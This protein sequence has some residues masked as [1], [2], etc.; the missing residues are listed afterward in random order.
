MAT[1]AGE[2]QPSKP[3]AL[4]FSPL[5]SYLIGGF[6]AADHR[7]SSGVPVAMLDATGHATQFARNYA[8]LRALG[9]R[10]VRE[11]IGWSRAER[12]GR[13]DF[14]CALRRADAARRA[15][16]TVLWTLWHY[17]IPDDLGLFHSSLADR[18]AAFAHAAA[19]AL[20]DDA[21]ERPIF[22]PINEISFLAWAACESTYIY[23]HRGSPGREASARGF[24]LK[25]RLVRAAIEACDA[26]REVTPSAIM[27]HID[28]LI[29]IVAPDDAPFLAAEAARA[30]EYQFQAWDMLTG[31][32]SPELG[33]APRYVDW[34]GVNYYH[35]NQ[36]EIGTDRRLHWHLRDPRRIPFSSLLNEV[37]ARYGRPV[38]VAETSHVGT[39]R[40]RWLMEV[41]REVRE[42]IR[43][44]TRVVGLCLYP[45]VDRPD[46]EEPTLW[47][48]SGL[49]D[50]FQACDGASFD[51][52]QLTYLRA[53]R[54][55][56]RTFGDDVR[57]RHGG[58]YA[59]VVLAEAPWRR[60][61]S[62]SRVQIETVANQWPVVVVEP[63]V[64]GTDSH[65]MRICEGIIV[66]TPQ[67][68]DTDDDGHDEDVSATLDALFAVLDEIGI[69]HYGVWLHTPMA[70]PVLAHLSPDVI[71][72]TAMRGAAA[73][74]PRFRQ[75]DNALRRIAD[76]VG[77][78]SVASIERARNA[79]RSAS[80]HRRV[81]CVIVGAGLAGLSAAYHYGEG[82]LLLER[83][84]TIGGSRR[85]VADGGFLFDIASC[86][87]DGRDEWTRL[88]D[89]LLGDNVAWRASTGYPL[90]GGMQAL[91]DGFLPLLAGELRRGTQVI[92][93]DPGKRAMLL[94]DGS[95]LRYERAIV[96]LPL[97]VLVALCEDVPVDVRN[98]AHRLRTRSLRCL[99][100]GVRGKAP[101]SD[102]G[103]LRV[104]ETMFDR[105]VLSGTL[106][107]TGNRRDGF[108]LA[109]EIAYA[110][111]RPLELHG[112]RLVTRCIDDCVR[113]GLIASREKVLV[114]NE[115]DLPVACVI[116]D[117]PGARNV[118]LIEGW[119]GANGIVFTGSRG[120]WE[121]GRC[122]AQ[123]AWG[124]DA[125]LA[126]AH[127][128]ERTSVASALS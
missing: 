125:A 26:I 78:V 120:E 88:Y 51:R 70:L 79:P 126:V 12:D 64:S 63:V 13:F 22:C 67:I 100:I 103:L 59:M 32:L 95:K 122:A 94:D 53:V 106:S 8:R 77:D 80:A 89:A 98:A 115:N 93:M 29:H 121:P 118:Q 37:H 74:D 14:G 75:R 40:A 66:V 44:G 62:E 9:I 28:P 35:G 38:L 83:D 16:I 34:I 21:L 1:R 42:A 128:S 23:P 69:A 127:A 56:Q 91:V 72:Y 92:R 2:L 110:R 96:N 3:E 43:D 81:E 20:H 99:N 71:A 84:T 33:G 109:C 45:I 24:A 27:L 58:C 5:A 41:S 107:P 30:R 65:A 19:S 123:L 46:W 10:V 6:E 57:A 90:Y 124:R 112:S 25:Q 76:P 82:S 54:Y 114:T 113:A 48:R 50:R 87:L 105:I 86:M 73:R 104:D 18:F 49:W 17:G 85:S 11:S 47:H 39:G 60:V 108:A 119:L 68:P 101:S 36:F 7:N 31:R 55:A 52:L 97:P 61:P 4:P 102:D 111:D 116:D 15:G 117:D